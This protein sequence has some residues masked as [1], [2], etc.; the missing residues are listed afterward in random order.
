MS[1]DISVGVA[2]GYGLEGWGSI[3][4]R[5]KFF[6]SPPALRPTVPVIQLSPWGLSSEI[7]RPGHESDHS[8]PS[9]AKFKNAGAI[10]PSPYMSSLH[11]A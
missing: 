11:N 10:P 6:S 3:P 1:Q 4:I 9:S 5:G 8:P 2:T 7:K